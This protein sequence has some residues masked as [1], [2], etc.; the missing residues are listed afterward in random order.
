MSWTRKPLKF[1]EWHR[2]SESTEE[3]EIL[4][5]FDEVLRKLPTQRL[6]IVYSKPARW[7]AFYG[8]LIFCLYLR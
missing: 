1:L 8:R 2:P 4:S 6:M 7:A 5:L 3:L